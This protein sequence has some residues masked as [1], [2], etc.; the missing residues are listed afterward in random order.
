MRVLIAGGSGFIGTELVRQLHEDGHD[1]TVLVRRQPKQAGEANW[2]PSAGI[3]DSGLIENTDAVI[4][5]SGA[6]L[7]H[8]PWTTGYKREILDSRLS[9]TRTLTDAMARAT[10]KPSVFLSGSAVGIYGD[11]PGERLTEESPRGAGFLGDVVEKWE[12]AADLAPKGTRTVTLRTGLVI[13]H[14]GS[15]TPLMALTRVG[16]GSRLATGGDIWP[17]I[18]LHD[19][20]AAIRH[21]LTSKLSGPVNLAG[22]TAATSD[23]VT[24]HLAQ[25]MHRPYFMVAPAF[26]L[27]AALQSAGPEL[28]L[29][30]QHVIPGRLVADGFRFRDSTVEQAIDAVVG[31]GD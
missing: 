21:L 11:R 26:A 4:N 29:S 6:S 16:L 31:Q 23:R 2:A 27:K 24:H 5:L 3:I 8:L 13:G 7:G 20:A 28:L 12:Q 22:P 1:I 10:K 18:G 19:E 15:L 9:A 17:W 14:G 30:S 25:R